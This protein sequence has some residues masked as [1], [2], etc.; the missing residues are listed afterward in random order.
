MFVIVLRPICFA[1]AAAAAVALLF[2]SLFDESRDNTAWI[3]PSEAKAAADNRGAGTI[4]AVRSPRDVMSLWDRRAPTGV[5]GR[6]APSGPYSR[7]DQPMDQSL[8]MALQPVDVEQELQ[9]DRQLASRQVGGKAERPSRAHREQDEEWLRVHTPPRAPLLDQ[10]KPEEVDQWASR[11]PGPDSTVIVANAA[12]NYEMDGR[13]VL[14]EGG[15]SMQGPDFSLDSQRL[16]VHMGDNNTRPEKMI[17]Y[18]DVQVRTSSNGDADGSS[19][20][21]I[22]A[23]AQRATFDPVG[24]TLLLEGWPRLSD[25]GGRDLAASEADTVITIHTRTG[26][27]ET[28]GRTRSRLSMDR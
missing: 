26:K 5:S 20:G 27:I 15:V 18:G 1:A 21:V 17:A 14:F 2:A 7:F 12:T 23:S 25:S 16:D 8:A 19:G 10:Q 3:A 28:T 11:E 24:E 9:Q 22:N 13:L 6:A 4:G